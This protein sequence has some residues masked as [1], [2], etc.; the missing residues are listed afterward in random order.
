MNEDFQL[1]TKLLAVKDFEPGK[2]VSDEKVSAACRLWT[3][4]VLEENGLE[5][6]DVM[7]AVC[8]GGSDVKT[9]FDNVDGLRF[10][11]CIAHQLN[12]ALIDG[13]GLSA[14]PASSK[15][16]DAR[17]VIFNM[18]KDIEHIN[19]SE[20]SKVRNGSIAS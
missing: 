10:E 12:R 8:N 1:Q 5:P 3:R 18:R 20:P 19:K 9:A 11:W 7:G 16:T 15:N 2:D 14:T 13:F 6:S 4:Q 17:Q